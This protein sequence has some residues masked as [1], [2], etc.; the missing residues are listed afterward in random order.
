MGGERGGD[1]WVV[2]VDGVEEGVLDAKGGEGGEGGGTG[3]GWRGG[4]GG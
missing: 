4:L 1:A 3:G 2:H